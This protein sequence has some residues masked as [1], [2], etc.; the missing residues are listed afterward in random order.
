MEVTVSAVPAAAGSAAHRPGS[1]VVQLSKSLA[2]APLHTHCQRS[3]AYVFVL[4]LAV[5]AA[6]GSAAHRPGS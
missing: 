1:F 6:A 2:P 3:D 4:P 5:H